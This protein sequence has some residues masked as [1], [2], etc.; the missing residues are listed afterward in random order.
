MCDVSS[1]SPSLR[2]RCVLVDV[3]GA[4]GERVEALMGKKVYWVVPNVLVTHGTPP[5]QDVL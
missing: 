3:A 5:R 2:V 4:R 1:L